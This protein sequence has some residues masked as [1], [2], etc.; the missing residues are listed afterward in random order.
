VLPDHPGGFVKDFEFLLFL[1]F[2]CMVFLYFYFCHID[3]NKYL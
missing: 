3:L 2:D 1:L